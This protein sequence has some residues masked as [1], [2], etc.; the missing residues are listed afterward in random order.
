MKNIVL[1]MVMLLVIIM[2]TATASANQEREDFTCLM[3]MTAISNLYDR[4]ADIKSRL[5]RLE[6]QINMYSV[7]LND[8]T[9]QHRNAQR[10]LDEC[11][12]RYKSAHLCISQV[13]EVN[14]LASRISDAFINIEDVRLLTL[15]LELDINNKQERI[16]QI[17]DNF[18]AFCT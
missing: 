17:Q 11:K 12:S 4:E 16:Q 13:Q 5:V 7:Q 9:W 15:T 14:L 18:D 10:K 2:T 6:T 3:A 1:C 8:Y